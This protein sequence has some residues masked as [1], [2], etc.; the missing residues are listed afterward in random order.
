MICAQVRSSP[1]PSMAAASPNSW[2]SP[3]KKLFIRSTF[4]PLDKP[5]IIKAHKLPINP[6]SRTR[7]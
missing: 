1:Q 2:G 6:S 7:R 5:G 3:S 4:Q